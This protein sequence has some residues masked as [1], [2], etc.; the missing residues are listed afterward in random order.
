[1]KYSGESTLVDNALSRNFVT[2]SGSTHSDRFY[3][4]FLKRPVDLVV[5]VLALPIVT[6]VIL[7]L[8]LLARRDG[9]PGF[10]R[11]E[12]VGRNGRTFACWKMRTMV[13]DAERV[14]KELCERD[15]ACAE[16]WNRNQKLGRDPRIT[17]IGALMRATSLDE[18]PQIWN[19]LRGDM[20]LVGPRPFMVSQDALYRAG[21]GDAYYRMRPG[22]TGPWQ[23]S[24]RGG[25]TFVERVQ[26][27][28]DY[29]KSMSLGGDLALM[30]RTVTV[31]FRGTGT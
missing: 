18:L 24:G 21:G 10:F 31:V 3:A 29:W 19:V 9:G 7:V 27:D 12:R 28:S 16:E 13:V 8:W 30:F 22:I 26:F 2:P 1:M 17:R 5:A 23:I 4:Q 6:P 25:T 11:Q 20:S 14:L 15:P